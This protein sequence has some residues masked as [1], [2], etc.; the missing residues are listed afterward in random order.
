M[1]RQK[2]T[3]R[4]VLVCN[5]DTICWQHAIRREG[6]ARSEVLSIV[7]PQNAKHFFTFMVIDSMDVFTR[8]EFKLE[9]VD[10]LHSQQS[11]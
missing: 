8:K 7:C 5:E 10:S 3:L 11:C 9:I 6:F 2:S 4:L 1:E